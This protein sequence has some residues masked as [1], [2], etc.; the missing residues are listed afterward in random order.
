MTKSCSRCGAEIKMKK[1]ATGLCRAC[2]TRRRWE[3]PVDRNN[4]VARIAAAL[5][6]PEVSEKLRN[7]IYSVEYRLN[8][9]LAS[10]GQGNPFFGKRHTIEARRRISFSRKGKTS[11][12]NNPAWKGG[13]QPDPYSNTFTKFI[14]KQVRERDGYACREC[15]VKETGRAHHVHHISQNKQ[16]TSLSAFIT[17]CPKCHATFHPDR[18]KFKRRRRPRA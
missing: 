17:V 2:V 1:G 16:E 13:I 8:R 11:G 18:G 9:S 7:R 12:V 4:M 6:S 3:D 10:M 14:K 5:R 15:G